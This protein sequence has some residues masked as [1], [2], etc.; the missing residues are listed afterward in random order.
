MTTWVPNLRKTVLVKGSGH[1]TQQE[2]PA[3]GERGDSRFPVGSEK[4]ARLFERRRRNASPFFQNQ[5]LTIGRVVR[6][7]S[8]RSMR[9]LARSARR[10]AHTAGC[11]FCALPGDVRAGAM[12][13]Q[14]GE[15]HD[16]AGARLR[17]ASPRAR[18][19]R[20]IRKPSLLSA[21]R[22]RAAQ[23]PARNHPRASVV[24]RRV[25]ERDPA[26]QVGLRLD[27]GVAVVLMPRERLRVLGLLVHRLIPVQP[28]VGTDQ[29]VA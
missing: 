2:K 25:G 6:Q 10:R 5:V 24:D 17:P 26:G 19:P 13:R 1:W 27:V 3:R 28:H 22:Q 7:A 8:R 18:L 14:R 9:G 21:M 23:M 20:G 11:R 29:I 4:V 12:R 16:T 15:H